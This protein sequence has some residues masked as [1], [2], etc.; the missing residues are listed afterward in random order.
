MTRAF[1][2]DL[3]LAITLAY[4]YLLIYW[5]SGMVSAL[6]GLISRIFAASNSPAG[7][8]FA[9]LLLS[10]FLTAP[11]LILYWRRPEDRKALRFFCF[12]LL[13]LGC[14]FLTGKF[15]SEP[16]TTLLFVPEIII[17]LWIYFFRPGF[18]LPAEARVG[19]GQKAKPDARSGGESP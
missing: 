2:F 12:W 14:F 13:A 18:F 3:M 16:I 6:S 8:V 9:I 17:L 19:A 11:A 5:V 15:L 10:F 7:L 1:K 4:C